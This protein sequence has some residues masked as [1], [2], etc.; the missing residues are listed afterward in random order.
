MPF[1]FFFFLN[2]FIGVF[3]FFPFFHSFSL[4]EFRSVLRT[5][6]KRRIGRDIK[7]KRNER[8]ITLNRTK[9]QHRMSGIFFG[10]YK[11]K[12]V[13]QTSFWI[14]FCW[15]W[16]VS[17][18]KKRIDEIRQN[19]RNEEKWKSKHE[20]NEKSSQLHVKF[21]RKRKEFQCKLFDLPERKRG[22]NILPIDDV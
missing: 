19:R 5:F 9:I 14:L 15:G 22:K 20:I 6:V 1:I 11:L 12:S 8:Y 10:K 2:R 16:V 13:W 7:F 21:I 17:A 4:F 3:R 18:G